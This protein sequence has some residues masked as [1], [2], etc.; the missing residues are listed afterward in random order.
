MFKK[1]NIRIEFYDVDLAKTIG[2]DEQKLKRVPENFDLE[3]FVEISGQRYRVIQAEPSERKKLKKSGT[4]VIQMKKVEQAE[5]ASAEE[6]PREEN[7][8]AAIL[9][10]EHAIDPSQVISANSI[11]P[12]RSYTQPSKADELPAFT[13]SNEGKQLLE[14]GAW[15][16]RNIEFAHLVFQDAIRNEFFAIRRSAEKYALAD[17]ERVMYSQQHRRRFATRP[18][19]QMDTTAAALQENAF[20]SAS[21]L[22]GLTF[23]KSEGHAEEGFAFRLRSGLALYG[24]EIRE[25]VRNLGLFINGPRNSAALPEDLDAILQFMETNSLLLVDWGQLQ[26]IPSERQELEKWLGYEAESVEEEEEEINSE[27]F[28]ESPLLIA[29]EENLLALE[30]PAPEEI[31]DELEAVEASPEAEP[32]AA[33]VESVPEGNTHLAEIPE[34]TPE[35]EAEDLSDSVV[36]ALEAEETSVPELKVIDLED[37]SQGEEEE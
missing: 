24:L 28:T 27:T 1:K 18:L 29:S 12:K 9:T 25:Q 8:H 2:Y 3:T 6:K 21:P 10:G 23:M 19:G 4:L 16:W 11:Q 20:A 34:V 17:P 22:D 35:A 33:P 37:L 31:S 32:I 7:P 13:G 14:M 36:E 5:T 15:E 26:V 30:D